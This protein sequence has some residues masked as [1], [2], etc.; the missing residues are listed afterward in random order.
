MDSLHITCR[1][2]SHYHLAKWWN[3]VW[4]T[5]CFSNRI[6]IQAYL[7]TINCL[8]AHTEVKLIKLL[9]IWQQCDVYTTLS[10]F[11]KIRWK[12]LTFFVKLFILVYLLFYGFLITKVVYNLICMVFWIF[13]IKNKYFFLVSQI[14]ELPL[15][16]HI[17]LHF[18]TSQFAFY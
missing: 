3:E 14:C 6:I 18:I 16:S 2:D 15:I 9:F 10:L 7:I 1:T 11:R 12:I 5:N 17:T 8:L 4:T 13:C